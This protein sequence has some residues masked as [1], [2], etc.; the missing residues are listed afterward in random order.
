MFFGVIIE[1]QLEGNFAVDT[2]WLRTKS[3]P[4]YS[5]A[6]FTVTWPTWLIG[7]SESVF[8]GCSPPDSE[9]EIFPTSG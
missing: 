3:G 5:S 7:G 8:T 2:E 6:G 4:V 9:Q 1:K